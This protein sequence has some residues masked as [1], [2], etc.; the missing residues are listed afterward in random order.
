MILPS[1]GEEQL[2]PV[3]DVDKRHVCRAAAGRWRCCGGQ[4]L[5]GG[6]GTASTVPVPLQSLGGA[7]DVRLVVMPPQHVILHTSQQQ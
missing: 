2:E 3:V 5:V 7:Q 1:L 6:G 4:L